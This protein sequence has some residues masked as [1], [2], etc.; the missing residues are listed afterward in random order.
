MNNKIFPADKWKRLISDER[1]K[2]LNRT[3]FFEISQPQKD[4][5]WA[6]IGCGPGFFTLP[7][8]KKVKKVYAVDIKE[9]MLNIC[10]NRAIENS[11]KN[12]E[13]VQSSGEEF[14]L[15]ANSVSNVLMVNVLHEF[16]NTKQAINE[17][18]KILETNGMVYIIDWKVIETEFGPPLAHRIPPEEVI[19][20]FEGNGFKF[21]KNFELYDYY[22][23]LSFKKIQAVIL[24]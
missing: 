8:A 23:V 9:E 14:N 15:S 24:S 6:D 18:N 12:I 19:K 3:K 4:Q 5:V 17:I 21:I 2:I 7:L 13:F 1:D 11:I 16:N 10:R 20:N 22:Y